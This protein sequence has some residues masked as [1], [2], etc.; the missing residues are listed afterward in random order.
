[1][2]MLM[3]I[4]SGDISTCRYKKAWYE[5][6]RGFVDARKYPNLDKALIIFATQNHCSYDEAYVLAKTG[7]RIG[8]LKK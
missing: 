1:M 7:Q 5:C 2:M 8:S 4:G 6:N 3:T